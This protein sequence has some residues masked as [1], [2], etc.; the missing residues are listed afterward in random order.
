VA[1]SSPLGGAIGGPTELPRKMMALGADCGRPRMMGMAG[2][3]RHNVMMSTSIYA[4]CGQCFPRRE[5]PASQAWL[6]R[7]HEWITKIVSEMQEQA[8]RANGQV[9]NYREHS[10]HPGKM[11]R[12]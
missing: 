9:N 7:L 10:T 11:A 3:A 2:S 5:A 4:M 8:G 12:W 6:F 1:G